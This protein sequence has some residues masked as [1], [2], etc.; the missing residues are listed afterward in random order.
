MFGHLLIVGRIMSKLPSDVHAHVL[1]RQIELAMPNLGPIFY[2]DAWPYGPPMLIATSSAAASQFT[3]AHSLPKF[4]KLRNYMYPMT[5]GNDLVTMEGN[6]WKA[7]RNT[8][9]PGFSTGRL[10]TLVPEIMKDTL[11]FCEKLREF[12]EK[13][14]IFLMDE[15]TMSLSLDIIGRVAL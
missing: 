15:V 8:F 13:E 2:I 5:G 6:E 1:P 9:S 12:A 7:W 4:A 14:A 3:Q 11:I 10:M